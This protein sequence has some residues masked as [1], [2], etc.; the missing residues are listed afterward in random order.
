M[1]GLILSNLLMHS[2][3][4][5]PSESSTS[6][7]LLPSG[8]NTFY[9]FPFLKQTKNKNFLVH[10]LLLSYDSAPLHR[11][12]SWE[13]DVPC[14]HRVVPLATPGSFRYYSDVSTPFPHAMEE[15][16]CMSASF[17][18]FNIW[19]EVLIFR[20]LLLFSRN[21]IFLWLMRVLLHSVSLY[22]CSVLLSPH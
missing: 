5:H 10:L 2:P 18:K 9:A 17:A 15:F 4:P 14:L 3:R 7:C 16:W 6:Q 8:I 20:H 1:L 21:P 11:Q 19:A 12:A 13:N 22:S